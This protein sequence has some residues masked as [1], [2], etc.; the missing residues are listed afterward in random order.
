SLISMISGLLHPSEGDT[1]IENASSLR[2]RK[3]AQRKIGI[4]PQEIA[5][6]LDLTA[7]ENLVFWGKMYDLK[8]ADLQKRVDD[9]LEV[10]GLTD[11]RKDRVGT[12]SGGMKRRL[13]IGC[14]LLHEPKLLIMD[15]PT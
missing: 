1:F 3:K 15:E 5:L 6:Y 8:G 10:I 11:R 13:N 9:T 4:V 7:Q 14:A 12:F 2:Q